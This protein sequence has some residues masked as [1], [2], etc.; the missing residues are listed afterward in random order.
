MPYAAPQPCKR[1]GCPELTQSG[2]CKKCKKDPR[3]RAYSP[4][5]TTQRRRRLNEEDRKLDAWYSSSRWRSLRNSWI[6]RNPCCALCLRAGVIKSG[7]VVD[8]IVER[9]DDDSKRLDSE[10]LQTLCHKCHN[11][12][13]AEV[14]QRRIQSGQEKN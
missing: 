14:R 3:H 8:H 2:F 9:R 11:R 7:E 5:G 10:N 12:K 13:S 6:S 1:F 4:R